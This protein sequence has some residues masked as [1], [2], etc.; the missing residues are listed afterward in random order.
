[1]LHV[2]T[3]RMSQP[4]E[5]PPQHSRPKRGFFSRLWDG[6]WGAALGTS[7]YETTKSVL[8]RTALTDA[9][10]HLYDN[11]I[12]TI[13][14]PEHIHQIENL[15]PPNGGFIFGLGALGKEGAGTANA[16]LKEAG[17]VQRV[18][19]TSVFGYVASAAIGA[20]TLLALYHGR[21]DNEH[22]GIL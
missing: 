22:S 9:K 19:P 5:T 20:A 1:M 18:R 14:T 3:L 2:Y 4:I 12:G 17:S 15:T 10:N 16:L 7:F 13:F 21:P 8:Q 11:A 6:L